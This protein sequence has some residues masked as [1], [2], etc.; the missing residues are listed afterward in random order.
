MM[1]KLTIYCILLT[2][3]IV[4]ITI[5]V[6]AQFVEVKSEFADIKVRVLPE[7]ESIIVH[8]ALKG[9]IFKFVSENGNWIEIEMFSGDSRYIHNSQVEILTR[10]VSAPFSKDVC[11]KFKERL[12]KAKERSIAESDYIHQNILFDR[13]VLDIFHE[14]GLQ[15]V[16]YQIVLDRCFGSSEI[17]QKALDKEE[18]YTLDSPIEMT[19]TKITKE[20]QYALRNTYW[21]MSKEQVK[22]AER[23]S[24][25]VEEDTDEDVYKYYD[26]SL[27]YE[28]ELN[29]IRCELHYQFVKNRL[30]TARYRKTGELRFKEE[31][32]NNYK[33]LKRYFT[34]IYGRPLYDGIEMIEDRPMNPFAMLPWE[35]PTDNIY[36][37][38]LSVD[39]SKD[40]DQIQWSVS[41]QSEEGASLSDNSDQKSPEST[42]VKDSQSESVIK[43]LDWTNRRSK[44]GNYYYVEGKVKNISSVV[45]KSVRVKIESLDQYE[46]LVSLEESYIDPSTLQPNQT[47]FFSVM[48]DYNSKIKYFNVNVYWK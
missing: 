19:E 28:V 1:K 20:S 47:G 27:F 38:L 13:Y 30:I 41:Y 45:A 35:K 6:S 3:F 8:K 42:E 23:E 39:T 31:Y 36:L 25:L 12:E 16:V 26:G 29:G 11:P 33:N 7:I 44:T 37:I 4:V 14:F 32:V 21:G 15:P 48:V 5:S 18:N 10:G 22:K 9:D 34:N 40:K 46:K 17:T 43:I 2:F 24:I